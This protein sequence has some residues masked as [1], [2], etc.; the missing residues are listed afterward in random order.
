MLEATGFAPVEVFNRT[1]ATMT[2]IEHAG[3]MFER[4]KENPSDAMARRHLS[5]WLGL[6]PEQLLKQRELTAEQK[7]IAG[8]TLSDRTQ[9]RTT[10]LEIPH[11]WGSSG[12][13]KTITLF[14][15]FGFNQAKFMMKDII[16][17]ELGKGNMRPLIPLFTTIPA[18]GYL[19]HNMKNFIAGK[20]QAKK[21]WKWI[22][23]IY[24]AGGG[25][26]FFQ[27][28]AA[29]SAY[30][31]VAGFLGGTLAGDS[32]DAL[33]GVWKSGQQGSAKPITKEVVK[34]VPAVGRPAIGH[35][36]YFKPKQSSG[37]K[38]WGSL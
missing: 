2:G 10:P 36:D 8:A 7:K 32:A 28:L 38:P 24:S 5:K 17:K 27:D 14:K 33:E 29:S 22:I 25:A 3:K 34:R 23:D 12:L 15:N 6:D 30:G 1:L 9:F 35:M 13:A 18:L 20:E 11:A 19:A 21:Y 16:M 37:A 26:G 4:L 31:N